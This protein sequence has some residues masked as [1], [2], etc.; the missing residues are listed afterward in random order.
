MSADGWVRRARQS[1]ERRA[2]SVGWDI[3]RGEIDQGF[4]IR[5]GER[6][7]AVVVDLFFFGISEFCFGILQPQMSTDGSASICESVIG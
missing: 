6:I 5:R 2:A 1:S 3:V 7:K 4:C